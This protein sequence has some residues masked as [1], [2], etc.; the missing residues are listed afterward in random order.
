LLIADTTFIVNKAFNLFDQSCKY[1]KSFVD[2]FKIHNFFELFQLLGL[3]LLGCA[4]CWPTAVENKRQCSISESVSLWHDML[5]GEDG[6]DEDDYG[7]DQDRTSEKSAAKKEELK[8]MVEFAR[9]M[10]NKAPQLLQVEIFMIFKPSKH[11]LSNI[12]I[13]ISSI[14]LIVMLSI[15]FKTRNLLKGKKYPKQNRSFANV[16][17]PMSFGKTLTEY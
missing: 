11:I 2:Q 17:L 6:Y 12:V 9:F 7:W 8:F 4:Y 1:Q 5:L 3:L 10:N 15:L 14:K 13:K 16:N